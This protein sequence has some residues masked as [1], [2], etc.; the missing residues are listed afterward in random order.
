LSNKILFN[1]IRDLNNYNL[2]D[3][4]FK[5]AIKELAGLPLLNSLY[6]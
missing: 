3:A 1:N 2:S 6:V 5:S 4:D